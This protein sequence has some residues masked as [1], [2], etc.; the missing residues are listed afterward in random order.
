M[1][2]NNKKKERKSVEI[3]GKGRAEV[4]EEGF[5]W[6][7]GGIKDLLARQNG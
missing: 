5:V 3:E 1:N 2:K 4:R 6:R 7:W